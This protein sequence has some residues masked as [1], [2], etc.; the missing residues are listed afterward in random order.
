MAREC[1]GRKDGAVG[2]RYEEAAER[3]VL[4]ELLAHRQRKDVGDLGRLREIVGEIVGEI[5]QPS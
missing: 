3:R 5:A 2:E 1:L 4:G